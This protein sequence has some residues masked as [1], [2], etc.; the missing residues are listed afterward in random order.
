MYLKGIKISNL[1]SFPYVADLGSAPEVTFHNDK[2]PNVNLLIGPNGSGKSNFLT[3]VHYILK[4]VFLKQYVVDQAYLD[5][6]LPDEQSQAIREYIQPFDHV[7]SHVAFQDQP[8][9]TLV[10]LTLTQHDYDN[11]RFLLSHREEINALIAQ[12]SHLEFAFD[13][14][15]IDDLVLADS[16]YQFHCAFDISS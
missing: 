3:I 11:L 1:F 5:S 14:V 12:Y 4:S 6:S 13:E 2:S 7:F 8:S 9:E 10:R 15:N 16:T